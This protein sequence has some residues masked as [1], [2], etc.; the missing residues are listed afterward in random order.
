MRVA[1]VNLTAGGLSGG[2]LKYL[3][4]LVPRLAAHPEM[5]TLAVFVPSGSRAQLG[6]ES[7]VI[8]EWTADDARRG[9]PRL[10]QDVRDLRPD[11]VFIPTA[12]WLDFV[13]APTVIMVRNM[14]PLVR[15]F[16]GLPLREGLRNLA[17]RIVARRACNRAARVIAVSNYVR[18]FVVARWGI[19]KDSVPVVHHGADAIEGTPAVTVPHALKHDPSIEFLFTA[20]SIRA[21]RG[22]EDLVEALPGLSERRLPSTVVIAGQTDSGTS[23]YQKALIERSRK[24]GVASQIVWAGSLDESEMSWCYRHC[25]GFVMTSRVEACPNVALEAMSHGC[26]CVSVDGPPMPEFFGDAAV[27]YRA[28]DAAGLT[29]GLEQLLLERKVAPRFRAAALLRARAFTWENTAQQTVAELKTAI[30]AR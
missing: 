10:K 28:G 21:A 23:R 6:D 9:F 8:R 27:Y 17:R 24:L 16:S 13:P 7:T 29:R 2:Y 26:A 4:R 20:G 25:A 19:P 3:R 30:R 12:S 18:Q 5:E 15:P 11:V 14:E 22:L 1:I